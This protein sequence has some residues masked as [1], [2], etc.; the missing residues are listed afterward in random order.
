M[1]ALLVGLG[2]AVGAPLRFLLAHSL[3]RR[4]P[5]GTLL[6]NTVGSGLIG[7]FAALSLGGDAWALLATGFCGGLT[8]FSAFAVQAVE[9]PR[10]V[11]AA[12]VVVTA[13]HAVGA[14]T[15]GWWLGA[16]V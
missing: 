6:V 16:L 15:L 1:T 12:Y 5:S 11:A 9:R 8:T 14:C 7:L 13:V 2:A 3:D 10:T 4:W